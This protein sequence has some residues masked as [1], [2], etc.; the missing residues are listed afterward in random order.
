MGRKF[1]QADA[2]QIRRHRLR[3]A[4]KVQ[5]DEA[6]IKIKRKQDYFWRAVNRQCQVIDIRSS[7]I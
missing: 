5:L 1:A 6:V 2:N 4:D 7:T 3:P